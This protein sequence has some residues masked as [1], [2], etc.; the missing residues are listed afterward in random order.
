MRNRNR[1]YRWLVVL[2]LAGT[3][4]GLGLLIL[5][6]PPPKVSRENFA[7]IYEGMTFEEVEE[8]L[9]ASLFSIGLYHTEAIYS[10]QRPPPWEPEQIDILVSFEDGRVES[11]EIVVV[12][13]TWKARLTEWLPW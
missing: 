11:T 7:K 6:T 4:G 13:R 5:R 12:E 3:L 8:I 10:G 1:P 2:I 9:G